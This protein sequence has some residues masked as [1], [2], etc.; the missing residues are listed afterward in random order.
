M[1]GEVVVGRDSK[2]VVGTGMDGGRS[3]YEVAVVVVHVVVEEVGFE[4]L[5][6]LAVCWA[7]W[8]WN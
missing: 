2:V 3:G 8:V 7:Y 5:S 4:D 1:A 6:S